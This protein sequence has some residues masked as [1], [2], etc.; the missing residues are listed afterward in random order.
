MPAAPVRQQQMIRFVSRQFL[1]GDVF[2]SDRQ[3]ELLLPVMGTEPGWAMLPV[4]IKLL[5]MTVPRLA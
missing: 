5:R 3:Q 1:M 4:V 2:G